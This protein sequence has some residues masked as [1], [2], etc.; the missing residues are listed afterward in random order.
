MQLQLRMQLTEILRH[1][2]PIW[3]VKIKIKIS[4][5]RNMHTLSRIMLYLQIVRNNPNFFC[6]PCIV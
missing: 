5:T 3:F 4:M 1:V 6:N 2:K